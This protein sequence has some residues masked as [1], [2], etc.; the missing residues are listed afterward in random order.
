MITLTKVNAHK[1]VEISNALWDA[2]LNTAE[3]K[4]SYSVVYM[5]D[6][7]CAVAMPAEPNPE[8]YGWEVIA[9]IDND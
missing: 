7:E 8:E 2:V 5:N 4:V 1:A 3:K 6:S 9:T